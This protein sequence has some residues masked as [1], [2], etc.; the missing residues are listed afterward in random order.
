MR[1]FRRA[2]PGKHNWGNKVYG[3]VL[4]LA[5]T[6][7]VLPAQTLTTL[8]NFDNTSSDGAEPHAGLVQAT[9]GDLYGA[10]AAGGSFGGG[11]VFKVTPGGTLTQVYSF[12]STTG[13]TGTFP[14]AGLVQAG[15]GDFYGTTEN[16][17]THNAGTVFKITARGVL[18]TLYNFCPQSGC[19]DGQNPYAGLVQGTNGDFYGTTE[20]GGANGNR[21]TVFKITPRGTLT[22]LHSF[23]AQSACTDGWEPTAGLILATNGEFYG[24]TVIGGAN[25]YGSVFK[26]SPSGKLTT[27]YSFCSQSGCTDGE[28]PHGGLV[29]ATNGDF[30]G[31]TGYGGANVCLTNGV[32]FGCGTVFK[33]TPGGKLTTLHS[34]CSL[35]ACADSQ[36]PYATLVQGTDGALYGTTLG[37]SPGTNYFGTIFKI[38]LSGKLTTLYTFCSQSACADG[39]YPFAGLVQETNGNFYGTTE[40][41]GSSSNC[42]IYSTGANLGCGTVFRLSVGLGPFVETQPSSGQVGAAVNIL[43]TNLKSASSVL[44]NGT[45]AVFTVVSSSEITTTVP[46]GATTGKV[47]VTASGGT[48]SS[49]KDFQVLP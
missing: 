27:V 19:A 1:S 4:L 17:G 5:S 2:R 20:G 7:I 32:N 47:Q 25:G 36:T 35:S 6:A 38:T 46:N 18:T 9:N 21:G 30:Y 28:N 11:T 39:S 33:V 48:L 49:N 43:G 37:P 24:T 15:N 8:H 29:Q 34:F 22:T 12:C 31:T 3:V 13:C 26:I 40:Y 16:G 45:T 44:F 41:G 23:C 14:Y 10:T 42:G